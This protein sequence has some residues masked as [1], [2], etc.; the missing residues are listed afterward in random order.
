MVTKH[1]KN[2]QS[3]GK[4][5]LELDTHKHGYN[6]K[7]GMAGVRKGSHSHKAAGEEGRQ[8][9]ADPQR[10]HTEV[11]VVQSIHCRYTHRRHVAVCSQGYSSD[12][13]H[14]GMIMTIRPNNPK[15]SL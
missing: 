13:V 9:T 1:G 11:T 14:G 8:Q 7:D 10:I 5:T 2:A 3:K 6:P 4:V 12:N 15:I